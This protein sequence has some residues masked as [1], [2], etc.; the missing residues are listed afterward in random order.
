[1]GNIFSGE[2]AVGDLR[3]WPIEV[4]FEKHPGCKNDHQEHENSERGPSAFKGHHVSGQ[5]LETA[6]DHQMGCN[7][8][9]CAFSVKLRRM[10]K[11]TVECCTS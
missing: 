6:G 9:R 1:V 2:D 10:A 5:E 7:Q 3:S 8:Q 11:L 4:E